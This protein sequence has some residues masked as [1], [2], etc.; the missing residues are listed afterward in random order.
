M[1]YWSAWKR[2]SGFECPLAHTVCHDV[3][4][5]DLMFQECVETDP[6][7]QPYR[8]QSSEE[9]EMLFKPQYFLV[10]PLAVFAFVTKPDHDPPA[11]L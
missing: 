3:G 8:W 10:K 7:F 4:Q 1:C 5:L 2:T 9:D 6:S 11:H